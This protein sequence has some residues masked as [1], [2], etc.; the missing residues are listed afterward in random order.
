M[1]TDLVSNFFIVFGVILFLEFFDRTNFAVIALAAKQPPRPT[2]VGAALAFLTVSAIAVTI[3]AAL[4]QFLGPQ[5][6]SYLRIG[7]GSLLIAYAIFLYFG[8]EEEDPALRAVPRSAFL[9]A[10][11]LIFLLELG[12]T[13]MIFEI[14]FVGTTGNPLLVFVAGSLALITVAATGSLVGSRLGARVEPHLLKRIVVAVL[15]IVGALT[16]LY[17]LAP[18]A[19]PV[20]RTAL[21]GG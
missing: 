11:L 5:H 14:V 13:T 12:D 7:G 4:T 3:G 8:E 10:F 6:I 16:I 19:F 21:L 15:L 17:G 18:Q 20:L 1:L 2:W 9:T